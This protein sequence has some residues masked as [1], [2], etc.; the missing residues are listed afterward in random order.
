MLLLCSFPAASLLSCGAGVAPGPDTPETKGQPET[1]TESAKGT[2]TSSGSETETGPSQDPVESG[3]PDLLKLNLLKQAWNVPA[4]GLRFFWRVPELEENT[5]QQAYRIVVG[6]N[7]DAVAGGS[8]VYDSG[9]VESP[10]SSGVT[11]AGLDAVLQDGHAYVWSVA[12]R[13][14]SGKQSSFADPYPFVTAK[15]RSEYPTVWASRTI[16]DGSMFVNSEKLTDITLEA[17]FS[18]T[19]S[20]LGFLFRSPDDNHFYMWQFMVTNGVAMFN[21]HVFRDGQ[22][23]GN[24]PI[25]RVTVPSEVSFDI[26]DTIHVKIEV[27]G[28][29]VTTFL[30]DEHDDYVQIDSRDM[31]DYGFSCGTFGFRT[32]GSESGIIHSIE[33]YSPVPDKGECLV[34]SSDFSDGVSRFPG[35]KASES[36][37]TVP[38][39][40]SKGSRLTGELN[41]GPEEETGVS[42]SLSPDSHAFFRREFSVT[43]DELSGLRAAVL[44]I[45]ASSPESA[46]QH[47]YQ[48]YCNGTC[49]G[50]GPAREG[51]DPDGN[52]VL[53]LDAFDLKPCL[54]AG[55]NVVS[56][57]CCAPSGQQL[58]ASLT[59]YDASGTGT[60][61]FSSAD[62][63]GWKTLAADPVFRPSQSIGTGYY[64]AMAQNLDA[65]VYPFGFSEAGFSGEGWLASSKAGDLKKAYTLLPCTTS[66]VQRLEQPS[67]SVTVTRVG[68]DYVIDLGQEIIGSFGLSVSVPESCEISLYFGERLNTDGTVMYRMNTGNVYTENW[69]LKAGQQDLENFDLLCFRYVQISGCPVAVTKDMVRGIAIRSAFEDEASSLSSDSTLLLK[70]WDLSKA[71]AKYTTQ[72]LF[73]DSQTR[74]RTAYEGDALINQLVNAAYSDDFTVARFS[75]EYLLDHRTWPAEYVL[76]MPI[77]ANDLYMRTGDLAA[78]RDLYPALAARQFTD[79]FDPAHQLIRMAVKPSS[80]TDSILVDWPAAE[81]FGYDMDV[82]YN[83][84]F[85]ALA[86]ASYRALSSLA[87]ALGMTRE[88]IDYSNLADALKEGLIDRLY[89]E[90]SGVFYDGLKADGTRSEHAGQ[91]ATSF[92][93]YAGVYR[94]AAMRDAMAASIAG[95]G[96][97]QGS[98]Y[99]AFFLL[100]GLYKS[101]HGDVADR[102]LLS[103]DPSDTHTWAYM[104]SRLGVTLSAEAW[105]DSAKSNLS[106]SHPWGATPAIAIVNGIFGIRPT[107]PGFASAEIRLQP[108]DLTQGQ[109]VSPTIRGPIGV[110]FT[111]RDSAWTVSASIPSNMETVL[112][113]PWNAEAPRVILDGTPVSAE[114]RDGFLCLDLPCGFHTVVCPAPQ[115]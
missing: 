18:I 89:D 36:G 1:G 27:Y 102:L 39:A 21:P 106:L 63:D 85:N 24:A 73:V 8:Y 46:R 105:S 115:P 104:L 4:K 94:D 72:N 40:L 34:Y 29:T 45:T 15:P 84:A 75:L 50:V 107:A 86:V 98:V 25:D 51:K 5:V 42:L 31:S 95:T 59:L 88:S 109:L 22:Y 101:G 93:L 112:M 35:C 71:T 61:R 37:L 100:E 81:R 47:V 83:T 53:Y 14:P 6:E 70:L 17:E 20:A 2:E 62:A 65:T 68:S 57:L 13:T 74:E 110:D 49:L 23:V 43:R 11:P 56:V 52:N 58:Y 69:K 7:P 97:I 103:E 113:I 41:L 9:W 60:E 76:F 77:I 82:V 91:H 12:V 78:I 26:G 16:Q 90:T 3:K 10:E 99:G 87:E 30:T 92:A 38:R 28:Q 48:V 80:S 33:V 55:T 79:R 19:S 114:V 108:G 96:R 44:E 67:D 111:V 32:G 64:R 54:T 66:P